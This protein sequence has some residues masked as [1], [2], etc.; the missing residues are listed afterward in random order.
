MAKATKK[1]K[2]TTTTRP[3]I[4]LKERELFWRRFTALVCVGSP[5]IRALEVAAGQSADAALREAAVKVRDA[6]IEGIPFSTAMQQSGAFNP[7]EVEL[8]RVGEATGTLDKTCARLSDM[9]CQ[10]LVAASWHTIP[11]NK[12]LPKVVREL[13][14]VLEKAVKEGAEQVVLKADGS[15]GMTVS[16]RS[17]DDVSAPAPAGSAAGLISRIKIMSGLDIAERRK[18]Q[19][20][21]FT[22]RVGGKSVRFKANTAPSPQGEGCVLK[23]K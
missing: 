6:L 5:L 20:G 8:V 11:V 2:R 21:S 15:G 1:Q 22:V 4:N 17:G 12:A 19:K 23:V 9:F 13:N 3:G 10:G 7:V 16:Y 14:A 18:P